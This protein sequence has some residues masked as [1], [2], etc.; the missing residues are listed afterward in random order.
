[1]GSPMSQFEA[2]GLEAKSRSPIELTAQPIDVLLSEMATSNR[3]N[4]HITRGF[5]A[6]CKQQRWH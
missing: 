5:A 4:S 6:A 2:G 3:I 1:M